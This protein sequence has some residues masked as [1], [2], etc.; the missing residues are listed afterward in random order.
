MAYLGRKGATAP[1]T[2]AD[3][4]DNS[5]TSAK[6]VADTIAAGDLAPNSVD[7]SELVDGSIDT[8]HIGA[9]QVTAAKVAADVATTAGTQTFTNKTL[10]SPVLTTP[11]LGTVA[12]GNLSNTAI[13]YP[14]GH[15]LQ[16]LHDTETSIT[17]SLSSPLM[18]WVDVS[19]NLNLVIT[20]A[21]TSN[22]I[23]IRANLCIGSV[24]NGEHGMWR[25]Y[26]DGGNSAGALSV[27]DTTSSAVET[28][29]GAMFYDTVSWALHGT[30]MR[31]AAYLDSPSSIS[32]LTY[33][34]QWYTRSET[35][36]LNRPHT[37]TQNTEHA[38]GTSS[39]T[40]ME[41]QG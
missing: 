17:I 19:S 14:A 28:T 4:P 6:I 10:T 11:A 27:G 40:V 41:I 8:S 20:P 24:T 12:T 25:F 23:L 21:S 34:I 39:L 18:Q 33:K 15:I 22:K 26:R 30:D 31:S 36:Y 1:L 5:I 32:A 37:M 35:T 13:V 2:S 16:V 7:S 9:N 38:V 29:S 3:I